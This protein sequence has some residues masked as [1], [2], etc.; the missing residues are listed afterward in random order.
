MGRKIWLSIYIQMIWIF[1]LEASSSCFTFHFSVA[2]VQAQVIHLETSLRPWPIHSFYCYTM[3]LSTPLVII[4]RVHNQYRRIS[5]G[6]AYSYALSGI[7]QAKQSTVWYQC[8]S[9]SVWRLHMLSR[10]IYLEMLLLPISQCNM[11][12]D[13][14]V[15][16]WA[17]QS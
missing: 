10:G 15:L 1:Y 13:N 14:T 6:P 17:H 7:L 11:C 9:T 2:S 12:K 4:S 3:S 5:H 16:I 8:T